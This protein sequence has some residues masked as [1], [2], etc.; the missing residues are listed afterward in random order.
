MIY[1]SHAPHKKTIDDGRATSWGSGVDQGEAVRAASLFRFLNQAQHREQFDRVCA[2][3]PAAP[4]TEVIT[5]TMIFRLE[6]LGESPH[7]P[8]SAAYMVRLE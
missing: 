8:H 2:C 4:D 1:P 5:E 7:S 6:R 3:L